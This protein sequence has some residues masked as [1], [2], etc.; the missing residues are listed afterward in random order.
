MAAVATASNLTALIGR[1][2]RMDPELDLP[3]KQISPRTCPHGVTLE[4]DQTSLEAGV[5]FRLLHSMVPS[6]ERTNQIS[7]NCFLINL[8]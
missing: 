2:A 8:I 3:W 7:D 4:T 1:A 6:E 5:G